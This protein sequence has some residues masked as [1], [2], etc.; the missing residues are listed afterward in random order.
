MK[1]QRRLASKILKCSPKRV[2][3]DP[4]KLA[5]IKEAITKA[6]VRGLIKAGAIKKFP[7]RGISQS[8]TIKRKQKLRKRH[9]GPGSRKG[10]KT[11]R[12]PRKTAWVNRVRTQRRFIKELRDKKEI[13]K[14][15]YSNLYMKCKGGFFRS[16]RH[17]QLYLTEMG[18]IKK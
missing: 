6:D 14:K 8:R 12:L 16:K 4:D 17:I 2:F 7:K 9:R 3:I 10:S 18:L 5:E 15:T 1:L 11:A 13:D